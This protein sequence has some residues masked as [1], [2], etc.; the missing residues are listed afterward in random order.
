VKEGVTVKRL[1]TVALAVLLAGC[2]AIT[3]VFQN[4]NGDLVRAGM[5]KDEVRAA[6]GDPEREFEN[7]PRLSILTDAWEYDFATV[8]F[9]QSSIVDRILPHG[10]GAASYPGTLGPASNQAGAGR[11]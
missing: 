8:Y 7:L 3:T 9:I 6:W 10:Q 11:P 4:P 5:T 1:L 2:V